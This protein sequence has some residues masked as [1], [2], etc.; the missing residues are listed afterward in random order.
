MFVDDVILHLDDGLG[1]PDDDPEVVV[2]GPGLAVILLPQLRLA[3]ALLDKALPVWVLAPQK[4]AASRFAQLLAY[5][6]VAVL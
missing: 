1:L 2:C 6:P 5:D 4:C 3:G